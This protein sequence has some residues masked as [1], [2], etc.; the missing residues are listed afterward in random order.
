MLQVFAGGTVAGPN[1]VGQVRITLPADLGLSAPV[2][3]WF[4]AVVSSSAGTRLTNAT[5]FTLGGSAS[6]TAAPPPAAVLGGGTRHRSHHSLP[7]EQR[8]RLEDPAVWMAERDAGI[9]TAVRVER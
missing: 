5:Q 1:N 7:F 8:I 6:A 2:P 3:V 9:V 4:Q